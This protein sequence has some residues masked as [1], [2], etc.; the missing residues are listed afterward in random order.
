MSEALRAAV[1]N[2]LREAGRGSA[3][4]IQ[5]IAAEVGG[6]DHRVSGALFALQQAGLVKRVG[7]RPSTFAATAAALRVHA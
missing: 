7:T 1:L 5:S 3:F 4:S 6:D 2:L